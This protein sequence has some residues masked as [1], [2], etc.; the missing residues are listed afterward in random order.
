MQ[1]YMSFGSLVEWVVGSFIVGAFVG[2]A[3][4]TVATYK[5]KK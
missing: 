5:K 3:I 4:V 2:G 1:M